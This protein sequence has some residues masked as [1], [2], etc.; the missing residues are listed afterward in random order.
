MDL[1]TQLGRF[2]VSA[3]LLRV[4]PSLL[5]VLS[6]LVLDVILTFDLHLENRNGLVC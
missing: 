2:T 1:L 3:S 6:D 5:F 4:F